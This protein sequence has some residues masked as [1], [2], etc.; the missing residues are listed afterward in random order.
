MTRGPRADGADNALPAYGLAAAPLR[1][2]WSLYPGA[3]G[4]IFD[5]AERLAATI[6]S[7]KCLQIRVGEA[8]VPAVAESHPAHNFRPKLANASGPRIGGPWNRP[9]CSNSI[10]TNFFTG[11]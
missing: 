9:V 5:G 1:P 10:P 6:A 8:A 2:G 7:P 4:Y 11:S 3:S